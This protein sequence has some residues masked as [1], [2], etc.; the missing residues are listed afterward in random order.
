MVFKCI[1]KVDRESDGVHARNGRRPRRARC[2]RTRP[3][4]VCRERGRRHQPG[5]PG[6]CA[7]RRVLHSE[8]RH[9]VRQR[10][11]DQGAGRRRDL[12]R[13]IRREHRRPDL[14]CA[15]ANRAPRPHPVP[16]ADQGCAAS[17]DGHG[18]T[19]RYGC[20]RRLR[21][22]APVPQDD[23][24][25]DASEGPRRQSL[26]PGG[27]RGP[28][29]AAIHPSCARH[30]PGLA[31]GRLYG[32]RSAGDDR[33]SAGACHRRPHRTGST[34]DAGKRDRRPVAGGCRDTSAR[35]WICRARPAGGFNQPRARC[36]VSDRVLRLGLERPCEPRAAFRDGIR[37]RGSRSHVCEQRCA[38]VPAATGRMDA[39]R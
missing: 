37:S 13:R 19:R 8:A 7:D 39:V 17:G 21:A 14:D 9:P 25:G 15:H 23:R 33:S 30:I 31:A 27:S 16:G 26:L 2:R 35:S 20:E 12:T 22:D 11:P 28:R 6:V 38:H 3:R 5:Q 29:R 36:E 4:P 10:H 24:R 34:G 18:R 1:V 32:G